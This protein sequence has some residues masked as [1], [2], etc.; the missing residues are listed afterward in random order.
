M[1]PGGAVRPVP[2][3]PMGDVAAVAD[4]GTASVN[5]TTF[6]LPS[7]RAC[8]PQLWLT[9]ATSASPLPCVETGSQARRRG[10]RGSWSRTE[11]VSRSGMRAIS[12]VHCLSGSACRCTLVSSSVTPSAAGS[13]SGSRCQ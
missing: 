5:Q 1:P 3:A 6:P 8:I 10:S 13:M 9:A 7:S 12:T 4:R 2:C 11:T